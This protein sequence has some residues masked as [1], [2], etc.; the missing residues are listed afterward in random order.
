MWGKVCGSGASEDNR[1]SFVT[2]SLQHVDDT[3]AAAVVDDDDGDDD[4][5]DDDDS[6]I[7]NNDAPYCNKN[8]T[9]LASPSR[10]PNPMILPSPNAPNVP[11]ERVVSFCGGGDD[12]CGDGGCDERSGDDDGCDE[13]IAMASIARHTPIRRT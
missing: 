1:L 4:E 11:L 12:G 8:E 5:G 7:P 6:C 2:R 9:A 13:R 10:Y 3:T